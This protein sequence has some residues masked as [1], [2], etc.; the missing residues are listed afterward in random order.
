MANV[1]THWKCPCCP[2]FNP[3]GKSKCSQAGC[4]GVRPGPGPAPRPWHQAGVKWA[5]GAPQ[6]RPKAPRR[7]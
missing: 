6:L 5:Q 1:G 3:I 2:H 7:R 4:S